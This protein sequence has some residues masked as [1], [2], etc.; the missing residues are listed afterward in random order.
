MPDAVPKAD[1]VADR[2]R[3]VA[4]GD[5]L[6]QLAGRPGDD[7]GEHGHAVAQRMGNP[8]ELLGLRQL[9]GEHAGEQMALAVIPPDPLPSAPALVIVA[10]PV[11]K[12][13]KTS[14][15]SSGS[16]SRHLPSANSY[17]VCRACTGI[18]RKR[19]PTPTPL[20]AAVGGRSRCVLQGERR[21]AGAGDAVMFAADRPC[22]PRDPRQR[23]RPA[24]PTLSVPETPVAW[25]STIEDSNW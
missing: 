17:T 2:D 18:H 23:H 1:H 10:T 5:Q 3:V 11:A 24:Q 7:S 9:G 19:S 21:T 14:R 15:N 12:R 25:S 4:A 20:V 13:P 22:P 6:P 8:F 16:G